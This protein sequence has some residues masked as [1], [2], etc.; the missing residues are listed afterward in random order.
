MFKHF[1]ISIPA[2]RCDQIPPHASY[3]LNT[4]ATTHITGAI[5]QCEGSRQLVDGMDSTAVECSALGRWS[6]ALPDQ[7]YGGS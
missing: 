5:I 4:D 1:F 6:T 3:T 7:C 2:E